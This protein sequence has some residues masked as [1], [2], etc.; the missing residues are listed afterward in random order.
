MC[1]KGFTIIELLVVI[2]IIGFISSIVL[3]SLKGIQSKARDARRLTD[4][5]QI[6]TALEMYY[7]S[8]NSYL[9]TGGNWLDSSIDAPN[10]ITGLAPT[11][12]GEVPDDPKKDNCWGVA[13]PSGTPEIC[14]YYRSDG[15]VYCMQISLENPP[16]TTNA[17]YVFGPE[18]G[19]IYKLRWGNAAYCIP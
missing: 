18:T 9:N 19:G 4:A 7:D 15:N 13:N 1:K 8:N 5:K 17:I 14:Y 10:W 6:L 16:G 3:V 11:Y 12:I 2:S